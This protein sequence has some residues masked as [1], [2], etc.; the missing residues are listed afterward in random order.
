[1]IRKV[2]LMLMVS[3]LLASCGNSPEKAAGETSDLLN[4]SVDMFWGD[5]DAYVGKN[6]LL[7]GFVVHVCQH[8]GKRMFVTGDD[9][10][11]R[12]QVK[13]G[14]NIPAFAIELEGSQLEIK[15]IID[16]LRIDEA[17]LQSWENELIADNPE[18]ELKIH[19]GEEGHQHEEDDA[20]YEWKQ[21]RRY[22]ELLAESDDDHLSFYS[23][24]AESFV[25]IE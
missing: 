12:L 20:E 8:G 7:D 5:P 6:V 4:I 1:M 15:G 9:P 22:R 14:D 16:E 2:F 19:R 17:Y 23:L 13:T 10:D 21:I 18:S 24:I 11:E 25:E 3:F